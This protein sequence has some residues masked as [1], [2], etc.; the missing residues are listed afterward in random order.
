MRCLL[1]LFA[2]LLCCR[3]AF[4][5]MVVITS[6]DMP[7]L[8]DTLRYSNASPATHINPGDSGLSMTWHYA[9]TSISQGVDTFKTATAVN[10]SYG[11]IIDAGA[12]GYKVADTI[13]GVLP[14]YNTYTFF[15]NTTD[16]FIAQA[17]AGEVTGTPTPANYALPDVW[18]HFPLSYLRTDSDA[19]E[20]NV[21]LPGVG[22]ILQTGYRSTRV[23]AWGTILTPFLASSTACIRVRSQIFEM[24]SVTIGTTGFAPVPRNTVEY[25]WLAN[26]EHY[27][28]LWVTS[29]V[30][31]ST[32]TITSIRYRDKFIDTATPPPP[33]PVDT[34]A[35]VHN[36]TRANSTISVYPNPSADGIVKLSLPKGW[37]NFIVQVYDMQGKKTGTFINSR[38]LDIRLFPSGTYLARITSGTFSGYVQIVR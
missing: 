27:P 37:T 15:Q 6:A 11:T 8:G 9:L 20:L 33:P 23:D 22:S 16:S 34:S 18:Y 7:V 26:G 19:Y 14:V 10:S 32:E 21:D 28:L 4:S 2:L 31:G 12:Y 13:P 25:K 30:T 3:P 17:F 29:I 5:Q 1:P 24:D 38:E 36:A 35:A